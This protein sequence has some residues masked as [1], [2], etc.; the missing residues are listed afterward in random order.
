MRV[1]GEHTGLESVF[2]AASLLLVFAAT[3]ANPLLVLVLA[4]SLMAL[5][6]VLFPDLRHRGPVATV[7]AVAA[8]FA[9]VR[10]VQSFVG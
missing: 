3:F 8:A 1:Q 4:V 7:I 6:S 5:G 10:L 2:I 9:L